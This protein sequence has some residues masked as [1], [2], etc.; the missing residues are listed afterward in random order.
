MVQIH[1]PSIIIGDIL[2]FKIFVIKFLVF[3]TQLNF[4]LY[5]LSHIFGLKH[6]SQ[7]RTGDYFGVIIYI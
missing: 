3:L 4:Q 6:G 7:Y 1:P 5:L 2:V